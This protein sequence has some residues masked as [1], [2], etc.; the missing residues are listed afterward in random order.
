MDV[1]TMFSNRDLDH[2]I[3]MDPP[4]G[5]ADFGIPNMVWKL[6]KSLY[7]LKQVSCAW[8][9]KAKQ[10]FSQLGFIQCNTDHSIFVHSTKDGTFCIIALYVD[11]L[12]ILSNDPITLGHQK[13]KLM[14]TFKMKDLRP[15]HWFLG[16]EIIHD[17]SCHLISVSQT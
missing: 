12:M 6:E 11:D 8:Y 13:D 10:E 5:S 15:I 16:L 2:T 4:L 9:Q 7:G 17:R 1:K 14:R 3:F